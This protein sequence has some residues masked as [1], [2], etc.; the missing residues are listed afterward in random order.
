MRKNL[1]KY[2]IL[3]LDNGLDE[4]HVPIW[5]ITKL[6]IPIGLIFSDSIFAIR[7]NWSSKFELL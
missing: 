6:I 2:L 1:K 5:F 3:K 7:L 4:E